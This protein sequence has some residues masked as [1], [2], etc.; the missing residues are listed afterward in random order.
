MKNQGCDCGAT[1]GGDRIGWLPDE[2]RLPFS[3]SFSIAR[4][5]NRW[6]AHVGRL[7]TSSS[8]WASAYDTSEVG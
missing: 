8:G 6:R 3:S 1:K 4:F 7:S 5:L 2:G